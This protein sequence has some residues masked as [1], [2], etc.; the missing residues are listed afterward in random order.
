MQAE[1]PS[2]DRNKALQLLRH[3]VGTAAQVVP[4]TDSTAG[5]DAEVF[6]EGA[7]P[8]GIRLLAYRPGEG[9][10]DETVW[11]VQKSSPALLNQLRERNENFIALNG[12]VRLVASGFLLD[13]SDLPRM[14]RGSALPRQVDPFSDRNSLVLRTLLNTPGRRWGVREIAEAAGVA[15][16][17]ASEVVRALRSL[18]GLDVRRR[19]RKLEFGVDDPLPLIRRWAGRYSYERNLRVAVAAPIGDPLRF[20]KRARPLLDARQWALT[21]QAGASLVAPHAAWERLHL[22]VAVTD[23]RELLDLT[24][25]AGW[26]LA[27]DGRLVLMKPHYTHSVWHGLREAEGFPVVSDLQLALDLWHYPLRGIEQAEHILST[28]GKPAS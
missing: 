22:Y 7:P 27:E 28:R 21:L 8:I 1:L 5:Y 4:R 10:E 25:E 23:G 17:T 9:R 13:R 11:V 16:G 6:R 19:G 20:L 3:A 18:G 24:H 2:G 12:A 15:V 26:P 14:P